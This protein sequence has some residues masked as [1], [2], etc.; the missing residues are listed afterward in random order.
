MRFKRRDRC[1]FNDTPRKRAA[2]ERKQRNEREAL[3]LFAAQVAAEQSS[4]DDIMA[5]RAKSWD[6]AEREGRARDASDWRRAR[7][8]LASYPPEEARALRSYWAINQ[9]PGTAIYLLSMMN[10][11]DNGRLDAVGRMLGRGSA[12]QN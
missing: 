1:P 7:A 8:K 12:A 6:R 5:A 10:M 3:P 2:L 11:F 9:W 4:A